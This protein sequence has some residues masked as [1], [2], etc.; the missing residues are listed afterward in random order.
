MGAARR[1]GAGSG[2][3]AGGRGVWGWS[4]D[5]SRSDGY[6][7]ASSDGDGHTS[8][9]HNVAHRAQPEPNAIHFVHPECGERGVAV[10]RMGGRWQH[11]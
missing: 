1:G 2:D 8:S 11:Q 7:Q 4:A 3:G 6:T 10:N 5:G 9:L